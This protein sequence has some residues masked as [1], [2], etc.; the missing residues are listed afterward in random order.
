[1]CKRRVTIYMRVCM[2][3]CA[4]LYMCVCM[5]VYVLVCFLWEFV[6]MWVCVCR[7]LSLQMFV[8]ILARVQIIS[9]RVCACECA[10]ICVHLWISFDYVCIQWFIL[11]YLLI[12]ICICYVVCSCLL[13][14]FYKSTFSKFLTEDLERCQL[15]LIIMQ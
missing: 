15:V 10:Y 9:A 13:K 7:C 12:N 14:Y 3:A 2:L 11:S 6:V 8:G 5:W 4:Y 1:M